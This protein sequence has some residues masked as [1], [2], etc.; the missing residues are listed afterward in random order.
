[1][2]VCGTLSYG[3]GTAC[4][5]RSASASC[6]P[7]GRGHTAAERP[8]IR[9]ALEQVV[10]ALSLH[11][12]SLP[13]IREDLLN[14]ACETVAT[15]SGRLI[16]IS[17]PIVGRASF[18]HE[19]GIHVHGLLHDRRTYEPFAPERVG[20]EPDLTIVIGKHS[21]S[22]ALEWASRN[23]MTQQRAFAIMLCDE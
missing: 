11:G 1:M 3:R 20:R 8:V 4:Q 17:Q 18:T 19:S 14:S 12:V 9:A 2:C 10:M 22:T 13:A 16:G 21:G 5:E 23:G 15:Y 6:A 7:A